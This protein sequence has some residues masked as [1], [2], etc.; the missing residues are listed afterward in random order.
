MSQPHALLGNDKLPPR[1]ASAMELIQNFGPSSPPRPAAPAAKVPEKGARPAAP[2]RPPAEARARDAGCESQEAVPG[3]LDALEVIDL[4][5]AENKGVK[6]EE[7][8]RKM[9]A[10]S[11]CPSYVMTALL[12]K[13]LPTF[14]A[15]EA[16]GG[17]SAS[18]ELAVLEDILRVMEK[19]REAVKMWGP[20]K[21][22]ADA[23]RFVRRKL[24]NAGLPREVIGAQLPA[25]TDLFI[26]QLGHHTEAYSVQILARC[27]F[28][29]YAEEPANQAKADARAKADKQAKADARAKA[30][31]R[32]NADKQILVKADA[33]AKAETEIKSAYETYE[34]HRQNPDLSG[35]LYVLSLLDKLDEK[36][37]P[38]RQQNPESK[39]SG[40][41][42]ASVEDYGRAMREALE[43][44]AESDRAEV[45]RCQDLYF[46]ALQKENDELRRVLSPGHERIAER[47]ARLH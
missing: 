8:L 17:P 5:R 9:M 11:G 7:I 28:K 6:T 36:A 13:H 2:A 16:Q 21:T 22:P 29:G 18:A 35:A 34:S 43:E 24:E 32:A 47:E 19:R 44:L 30:G 41:R 15:F 46:Q 20:D 14:E 26:Q 42:R 45:E 33:R 23:E 12:R 10:E 38:A 1:V 39:T 4:A 25:A 37:A 31:A 27:F 40:W 3:R